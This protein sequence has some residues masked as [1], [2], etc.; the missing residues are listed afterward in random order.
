MPDLK[1]LIEKSGFEVICVEEVIEKC[2][3]PS[4][5]EYLRWFEGTFHGRF[6]VKDKYNK[7]QDNTDLSMKE[8]GSIT[9]ET[10][11]LRAILRKPNNC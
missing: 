6:L 3:F 4:V 11:L 1:E 8:D 2:P 5:E 7:N 9:E 10:P